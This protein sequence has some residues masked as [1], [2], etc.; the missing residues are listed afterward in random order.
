MNNQPLVVDW[1]S[2]PKNMLL[3]PNLLISNL[4][5]TTLLIPTLL[6]T[7]LLVPTLLIPTGNLGFGTQIYIAFALL[8]VKKVPTFWSL[9]Y[10]S[11]PF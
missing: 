5:V 3:V 1:N 4:L 2:C 10:W 8:Q 7:T 11:P 6:V 9:T